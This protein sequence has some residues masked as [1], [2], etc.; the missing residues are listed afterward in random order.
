MMQF[1]EAVASYERHA[2]D[3]I[4][5]HTITTVI[6]A[7]EIRATPSYLQTS[8]LSG[9][10]LKRVSWAHLYT[11][12]NKEGH[13]FQPTGSSISLISLHLHVHK[14]TGAAGKTIICFH[15]ISNANWM[16]N[17]PVIGRWKIVKQRVTASQLRFF[18][19]VRFTHLAGTN[20]SPINE[21]FM[22]ELPR[23]TATISYYQP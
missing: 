6:A 1:H 16:G 21:M 17:D 23:N 7:L 19:V 9:L 20:R 14:C 3:T 8:L 5:K 13:W 2:V 22:V 4:R 10:T 15:R 12:I 11:S 18:A